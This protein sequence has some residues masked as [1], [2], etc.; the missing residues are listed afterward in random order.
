MSVQ[1]VGLIPAL[2]TRY[3]AP[4]KRDFQCRSHICSYA[5]LCYI[6]LKFDEVYIAF[7]IETHSI[8]N[9]KRKIMAFESKKKSV[10]GCLCYI[11]N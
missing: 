4:Y 7:F 5:K 8:P 6:T 2:G 3:V 1:G 11:T 9:G 10:C